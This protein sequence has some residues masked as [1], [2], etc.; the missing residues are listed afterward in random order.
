MLKKGIG[1]F[2]EFEKPTG[3]GNLL[4]SWSSGRP[5]ALYENARSALRELIIQEKPNSVWL[6]A[7]LCDSLVEAVPKDLR[8]FYV[9]GEKLSPVI[10]SLSKVKEGDMLLGI[11]YFGF[12]PD[13]EFILFVKSN[14]KIKFVEDCSHCISI[15]SKGWGDWRLFSPRKLLGVA[16]GGVLISNNLLIQVPIPKLE[17]NLNDL[18]VW[19]PNILR[20]SDVKE[21]NTSLWHTINQEKERNFKITNKSITKLSKLILEN[22]DVVPFIKQRIINFNTLKS[23]LS[24]WLINIDRPFE[25]A[26]F[27]FPIIIDKN[28]RDEVLT[29]F[30]SHK[31]YASIHWKC[32]SSSIE[33]FPVEHELSKKLISLPC[34]QRYTEIE[35][36]KIIK[37]FKEII[38]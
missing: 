28:I 18:T 23:E 9:V 13:N 3:A 4:E 5:V 11:N 6:P 14:K 1:G 21:I 15:N 36:W 37:V 7:F 33:E 34:D 32:I 38:K 10:S 8:K 17:S 25:S 12:L 16:D 20:Y 31:I 19:T 24:N 2:F 35:M 22:I 30:H 26:P 27:C 29:Y